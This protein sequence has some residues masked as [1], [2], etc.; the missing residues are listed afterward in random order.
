MKFLIPCIVFI[1][2]LLFLLFVNDKL[3][4]SDRRLV[5]RTGE[6][7]GGV[8][9]VVECVAVFAILAAANQP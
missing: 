1:A 8:A 9:I 4:K 5:R 7:I 2:L 6:I 3:V